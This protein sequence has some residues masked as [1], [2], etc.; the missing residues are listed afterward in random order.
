MHN[1]IIGRDIGCDTLSESVTHQL[2]L[3]QHESL[4]NN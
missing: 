3:Q 4:K 2:V 1:R